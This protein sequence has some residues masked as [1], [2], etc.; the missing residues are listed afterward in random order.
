MRGLNKISQEGFQNLKQAIS[1]NNYC[2]EFILDFDKCETLNNNYLQQISQGLSINEQLQILQLSF[3]YCN[4]ITDE[5]VYYLGQLLNRKKGKLV[6]LNLNFEYSFNLTDQSVMHICESIQD[7][8]SLQSFT[9]NL[10]SCSITDVGLQTL[11]RTIISCPNLKFFTLKLELCD[12]VSDIGLTSLSQCIN[13]NNSLKEFNLILNSNHEI[14]NKGIKKVIQ[15]LNQQ[16]CNLQLINLSL[17]NIPQITGKLLKYIKNIQ[18]PNDKKL[19]KLILTIKQC[20]KFKQLAF[21][22]LQA[23]LKEKQISVEQIVLDFKSQNF[24]SLGSDNLSS[25][26]KLID[27]GISNQNK[28]QI[29][30]GNSQQF[31]PNDTLHIQSALE[32]LNL[33]QKI[34]LTYSESEKQP[35][36]SDSYIFL[37]SMDTIGIETTPY[38]ENQHY[39]LQ[40]NEDKE[41]K[42]LQV[43]KLKS[44]VNINLNQK[45]SNVSQETFQTR[46]NLERC[47]QLNI[48]KDVYTSAKIS[49][50]NYSKFDIEIY[51]NEV[52]EE[53][54]ENSN[55]SGGSENLKKCQHA[56][57][58]IDQINFSSFFY[59]IS[60]CL[61]YNS[62]NFNISYGLIN[63]KVIQSMSKSI[64]S[65]QSVKD[66][67][68]YF[69]E[70]N[71]ITDE[72]L[73]IFFEDLQEV[74]Q[75][76]NSLI[77]QFLNCTNLSDK[78]LQQVNNFIANNKN[79]QKIEFIFSKS[80]FISD[81]SLSLLLE[82]IQ[83]DKV[84]KRTFLL[85]F[86]SCQKLSL[87]Q[88]VLLDK[89]IK[90]KNGEI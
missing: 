36:L 18:I 41:N 48:L 68:F 8:N 46:L 37:S 4:H 20:N 29:L 17:E 85:S 7:S 22:N 50:K 28:I 69:G 24:F 31:N 2:K 13:Q 90:K 49:S 71:Q 76:I 30:I 5:G 78:S 15:Q 88:M 51:K 21:E 65:N 66:W 82:T 19:Q 80:N 74:N 6:D 57:D 86:I 1:L 27:E 89:A 53:Y 64:K 84:Q 32:E 44:I 77:I 39:Y 63:D 72:S 52:N 56:K 47:N 3:R 16:A 45:G 42:E 59:S 9:L 38:K 70:C 81:K 87:K 73:T 67:Q 60:N 58:L 75:N 43:S 83:N 62:I 11:Q 25:Y 35:I 34:A 23:L 14:T 10:N 61:S 40:F 12:K 54:F 55:E 26:R 79:T 33:S